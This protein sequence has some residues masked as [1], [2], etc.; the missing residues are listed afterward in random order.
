MKTS[1]EFVLAENE[2]TGELQSLAF[3]CTRPEC[4]GTVLR[5]GDLEKHAQKQHSTRFMHVFSTRALYDDYVRAQQ[6]RG[7]D[8]GLLDAD[9]YPPLVHRGFVPGH[10]EST[11][12]DPVH[13]REA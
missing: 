13:W 10:D 9:D 8:L 1:I 2:S 12:T 7:F 5:S 6:A 3:E 4:T 11:C